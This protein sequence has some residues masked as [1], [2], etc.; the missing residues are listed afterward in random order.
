MD[1]KIYLS[2][3]KKD[4][5]LIYHNLNIFS[6]ITHQLAVDDRITTQLI[7]KILCTSVIYL[8]AGPNN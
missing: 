5:P 3:Y 2:K 6:N 7:K 8:C 4:S 1:L